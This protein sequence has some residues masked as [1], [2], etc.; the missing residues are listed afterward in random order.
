MSY[1]NTPADEVSKEEIFAN[2][3]NYHRWNYA[4]IEPVSTGYE[5]DLPEIHK[6][7]KEM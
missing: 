3:D 1:L 4:S 5:E 7:T 6:Y 2:E